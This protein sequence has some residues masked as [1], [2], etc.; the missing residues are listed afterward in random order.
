M[1]NRKKTVIMRLQPEKIG[2]RRQYKKHT[3]N[4]YHI[5]MFRCKYDTRMDTDP[6]NWA[7]TRHN[8]NSD[9]RQFGARKKKREKTKNS[10][11]II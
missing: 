4:V 8:H 10:L 11:L 2:N 9:C 7:Y 5:I 3:W 1:G 6:V